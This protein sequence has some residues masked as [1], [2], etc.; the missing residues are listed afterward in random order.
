[1]LGRF[2]LFCDVL[3]IDF[4]LCDHIL[5]EGLFVSTLCLGWLVSLY[6]PL[7]L[8]IF[9]SFWCL[10]K[11]PLILCAKLVRMVAKQS[12]SHT[13]FVFYLLFR[14]RRQLKFQFRIGTTTSKPFVSAISGSD[15]FLR[16]MRN[17]LEKVSHSF[18][19]LG[20]GWATPYHCF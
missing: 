9:S 3:T 19:D 16:F 15:S 8:V 6:D 5:A 1:M 17:M 4:I 2:L 7:P 14:H 11:F 13:A 12:L 10:S 18:D 20:F